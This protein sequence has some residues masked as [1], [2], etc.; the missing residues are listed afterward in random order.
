M[1]HPRID[2][3]LYETVRPRLIAAMESMAAAGHSA[4]EWA[5][6]WIEKIGDN[7]IPYLARF[8]QEIRDGTV[9]IAGLTDS[10]RAALFGATVTPQQREAMIRE[11]AYFRAQRRAYQGGSPEQDWREAEAQID[12]L[13]AGNAGLVGK[14]RQALS[15]VT[16]M[17]QKE[18]EGIKGLVGNWIERRQHSEH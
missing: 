12:R 16:D 18:L 4:R 10:A 14:G 11:A 15:S 2:E 5:E 7:E 9:K 13:L 6:F 8:L 3:R 1:N 17:A